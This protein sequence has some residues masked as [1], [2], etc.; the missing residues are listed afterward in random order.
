MKFQSFLDAISSEMAL[1]VFTWRRIEIDTIIRQCQLI[2]TTTTTATATTRKERTIGGGG[3]NRKKEEKKKKE[4]RGG[5]GG[6]KEWNR[7]QVVGKRCALISTNYTSNCRHLLRKSTEETKKFHSLLN[8][9]W[10]VMRTLA[11]RADVCLATTRTSGWCD[12]FPKL[13]MDLKCFILLMVRISALNW[14]LILKLVEEFQMLN[15]QTKMIVTTYSTQYPP[16]ILPVFS[17]P[18]DSSAVVRFNQRR[19]RL[20]KRFLMFVIV[21]DFLVF[22]RWMDWPSRDSG[23]GSGTSSQLV[24]A[25]TRT[26]LKNQDWIWEPGLELGTSWGGLCPVGKMWN[27]RTCMGPLVSLEMRTLGVDLLAAWKLALVDA[28]TL[29]NAGEGGRCRR[30]PL[31]IQNGRLDGIGKSRRRR[32]GR[33]AIGGRRVGSGTGRFDRFDRRFQ[34]HRSADRLRTGRWS[35]RMAVTRRSWPSRFVETWSPVRTDLRRVEVLGQTVPRPRWTRPGTRRWWETDIVEGPPSASQSSAFFFQLVLLFFI[36]VLLLLFVLVVA[37]AVH[38]RRFRLHF[39]EQPQSNP[40]KETNEKQLFLSSSRHI[41][42]HQST[43]A[44]TNESI[45]THFPFD[46]I[47][48]HINTSFVT[49]TV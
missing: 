16:C 44:F 8:H 15:K 23:L 49:P 22:D 19:Y 38:F 4:R 36:V 48:S 11:F 7:S 6:R 41:N 39:G 14:C 24:A 2:S 46:R 3:K 30:R 33:T 47:I 26:G 9:F 10:C 32:T 43:P 34:R 12:W 20:K 28:A 18:A 13:W 27:G 29:R 35:E 42:A 17:L 5:R 25:G 37:L 21:F 40:Q 45:I 1:A 31:R